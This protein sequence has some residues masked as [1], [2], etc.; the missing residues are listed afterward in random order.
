MRND[1]SFIHFIMNLAVV[2]CKCLQFLGSYQYI[3]VIF[4]G[5]VFFQLFE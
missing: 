3:D 5:L 1:L 4:L 2:N